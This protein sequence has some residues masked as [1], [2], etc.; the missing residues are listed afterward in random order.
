MQSKKT[1]RWLAFLLIGALLLTACVQ[2]QAP[3]AAPAA[4]AGSDSA[5]A[6]MDALVQ[7]AQAEGELNV[8]ALP[9]DWC[10]YGEAIDTFKAKYGLKV[11][12]INPD[13]GSAEELEAVRANKDNKGPQAP[14]VLDVGP[15]YGVEAKEQGLT[16]PYKVATWDTIP[17]NLKDADGHWYGDYYGV[18]SLQVNADV[19]QNVPQSYADLL[20]PEYKGQVANGD[21]LIGNQDVQAVVAAALANGGS[22]DDVSKGVEFFN[23]LFE[24]GNLVPTTWNA[25]TFAKGETPIV[26]RWD[27]LA[28]TQ[29]DT[30]GDN[31]KTEVIIPSDV[32]LGGFYVQAISAYAPHPNAAKL[33][34]EFLYSDEGQLIWLKGYCHPIRYQ[35]LAARGV[36]PADLAAKLPSDELYAKAVFPTLEQATKAK[37][38]ITTNWKI[39][40]EKVQ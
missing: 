7:A 5:T 20:K 30:N 4:S 22:V 18:M 38:Y 23:Q 11:N 12:E 13:A 26:F 2:Q 27:Y 37:E 15:A 34:M 36:I 14:D 1:S 19:V 6:G 28:L 21:P 33:W 35:D 25:A 17:E 10:N 3:S 40:L 31:P 9:R 8:I 16:T 29:R 24:M 39:Q 32:T